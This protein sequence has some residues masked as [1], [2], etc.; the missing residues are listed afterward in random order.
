MPQVNEMSE[1]FT[2]NLN[3]VELYKKH[4]CPI[5]KIE[6]KLSVDALILFLHTWIFM[7]G[8]VQAPW[9]REVLSLQLFSDHRLKSGQLLWV[10]VVFPV[11]CDP[12]RKTTHRWKSETPTRWQDSKSHVISSQTCKKLT[13]PQ[14]RR[15]VAV[16][17]LFRA[18]A[19]VGHGVGLHALERAIL[20][21]LLNDVF[22][23]VP[24]QEVRNAPYGSGQVLNER[25]YLITNT[26]MIKYRYKLFP[27]VIFF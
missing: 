1:S 22:T 6:T 5:W 12:C 21:Y 23:Q 16:H 9:Q 17:V 10:E 27:L 11:S 15:L 24:A 8:S 19:E 7:C 2:L 18:E 13:F 14:E 3:N 26:L 4:K 20:R 25:R